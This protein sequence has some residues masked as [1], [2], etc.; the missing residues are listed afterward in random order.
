MKNKYQRNL[1][2]KANNKKK[3]RVLYKQV[4][5]NPQIKIINDLSKLKKMIVQNNFEIIPYEDM[6]I[7]CNN[8][9]LSKCM[10]INVVF[11]FSHISGSLILVKI[12]KIKREFKSLSQEDIIWYAKDLINKSYGTNKSKNI[13]IN[14]KKYTENH[15]RTFENDNKAVSFDRA[16]VNILIN[17]EHALIALLKKENGDMKNE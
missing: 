16:V 9:Q 10:P 7:I 3:L 8:K 11:S 13:Q 5:K 12:D 15:E 14:K 1:I 2:A 17:I 6:F 4:G